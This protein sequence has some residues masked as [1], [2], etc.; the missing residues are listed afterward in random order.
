MVHGGS[1]NEQRTILS[2][3]QTT[4]HSYVCVTACLPASVFIIIALE[5][6]CPKGAIISISYTSSCQCKQCSLNNIIVCACDAL[7]TSNTYL[8]ECICG[9]CVFVRTALG[10]RG[11]EERPAKSLYKYCVLAVRLLEQALSV[12]CNNEHI[13]CGILFP[14]YSCIVW[15]LFE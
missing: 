8:Y 15:F 5:M 14:V 3:A 13:Y 10:K 2:V 1:G 7:Y 12:L 4:S 11:M 6:W 9:R